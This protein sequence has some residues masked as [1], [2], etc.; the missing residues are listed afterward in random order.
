MIN[1]TES[2]INRLTNAGIYFNW[3]F[4]SGNK[5]KSFADVDD[6]D[7][8][9][10]PNNMVD[11]SSDTSSDESL[12]YEF[13][14]KK[15]S[16]KEPG[17]TESEDDDDD[18][19]SEDEHKKNVNKKIS[20]P[21]TKGEI[22]IDEVPPL[23][24]FDHFTLN[25][26]EVITHVGIITSIVYNLVIVQSIRDSKPLDEDTILFTEDRQT[27]GKVYE[28]FGPVCQPYYSVRVNLN[29]DS[30]CKYLINTNVYYVPNSQELT[31]YIFNIEKLK[32]IKGSDASWSNDNEPPVE[33]LD[34]SDDEEEKAN[35]QRLK[36]AR[37]NSNN[38][39]N[40]KPTFNSKEETEAKKLKNN[41][42]N[43]QNVY[44]NQPRAFRPRF[45]SFSNPS[46]SFRQPYFMPPQLINQSFQQMMSPNIYSQQQQFGAPPYMMMG[47]PAHFFG[48]PRLPFN[49]SNNF[50]A[51]IR[52]NNYF[53]NSNNNFDNSGLNEMKKSF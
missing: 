6:D 32:A 49:N 21:K 46:Q 26:N 8:V 40:N 35:K 51:P 31:K 41:N 19:D 14:K 44:N 24:D 50:R 1:I 25:S 36:A 20:F 29:K 5:F 23:I 27:I 11:S 16:K 2:V 47:P 53:N 34:Y 45:N 3:F 17:V 18:D 28:T 15:I 38:N 10:I 12:I 39:N 4:K 33:C 48:Q 13:R 52:Q 9:Q 7:Y 30:S 37:H 22:T 43:H 42:Y